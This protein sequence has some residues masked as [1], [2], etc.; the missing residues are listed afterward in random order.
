MSYT[1]LN[2]HMWA[3]TK[4]QNQ[5]KKRENKD[6]WKYLQ[7]IWLKGVVYIL[8]MKSLYRLARQHTVDKW[9]KGMNKQVL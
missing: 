6:E 7:N 1:K 3:L 5:I 8:C 4:T 9:T 2:E